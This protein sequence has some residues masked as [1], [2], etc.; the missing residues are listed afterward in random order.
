MTGKA[1]PAAARIY[2]NLL[3][4]I[5]KFIEQQKPNV[6]TF[7]GA[8]GSQDIIYDVFIRRVLG[9][10]PG[11]SPQL[12]FFPVSKT[13][14]LSKAFINELSPKDQINVNR[15]IERS[16]SEREESVALERDRKARSRKLRDLNKSD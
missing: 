16:K 12:V 14:F 3:L 4:A 13:V 8:T 1:G 5:K 2:K 7:S 9:D 10:S 15:V 6:L 11:K